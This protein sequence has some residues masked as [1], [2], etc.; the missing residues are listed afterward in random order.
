[1]VSAHDKYW[2]QR[3]IWVA[4]TDILRS[5]ILTLWHRYI[6]SSY[7]HIS[8]FPLLQSCYVPHLPHPHVSTDMSV[9]Y[10]CHATFPAYLTLISAVI[11]PLPRSCCIPYS[12]RTH[13]SNAVSPLPFVLRA[14]PS[15]PPHNSSTVRDLRLP[16][17]K[18]SSWISWL[19]KM[20]P[21]GC[22]ETS[23]RN[24]HYTLHNN[25]EERR[26]QLLYWSRIPFA[27]RATCPSSSSPLLQYWSRIAFLTRLLAY[28]PH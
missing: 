13:I 24:Y 4:D 5:R 3:N 18:L 25:P 10:S 7:Q 22:P 12:C 16:R 14:R 19:L 20:R 27:S 21:I 2:Q 9:P 6:A 26:S 23:V 8:P 15:Y 28:R 11:C 1:M 17:R